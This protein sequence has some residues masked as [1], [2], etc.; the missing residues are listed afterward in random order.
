MGI[1]LNFIRPALTIGI[2]NGGV[3]WILLYVFTNAGYYPCPETT[4]K[5]ALNNLPNFWRPP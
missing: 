1:K 3:F 5:L 2:G 4:V